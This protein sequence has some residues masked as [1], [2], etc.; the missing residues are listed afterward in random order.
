MVRDSVQNFRIGGLLGSGVSFVFGASVS[1]MLLRCQDFGC[2]C[3]RARTQAALN[4]E[5]KSTV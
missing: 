5:A 3:L 4:P 1:G 2:W